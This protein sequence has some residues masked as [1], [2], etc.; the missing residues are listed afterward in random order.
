M[1]R[2]LKSVLNESNP[3]KL[4][5]ATQGVLLGS[6]LA[7]APMTAKGTVTSHVMVLPETAK[8]AFVLQAYSRAGTLKGY[9]KPELQVGG[10]VAT[11]EVG[12]NGNGDILFATA[13]AV[14]DAEV[15]YV[16]V[17]G[18]IIEDLVTVAASVG[19][20]NG[21]RKG[22][23]LL[24]VEVLSGIVLGTKIKDIRGTAAPASG[25]VALSDVGTTV[26]FNAA[27]VVA[28]TARVRYIAQPGEGNGVADALVDRLNDEQSAL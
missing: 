5:S 8:A 16:P 6:A 17:Q 3:N 22:A 25:H 26:L 27:D 18:E 20:L 12:V 24:S 11:T 19:T 7:A 14:T 13:D 9:L 21:S 23:L 4:A 1:S 10:A 28:G 2:S 15:I